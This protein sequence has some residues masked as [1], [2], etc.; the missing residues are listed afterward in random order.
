MTQSQLS[1]TILKI[2]NKKC[3]NRFVTTVKKNCKIRLIST[4]IN[5]SEIIEKWFFSNDEKLMKQQMKTIVENDVDE[6]DWYKRKLN[7][8][9]KINEI[10]E[11]KTNVANAVDTIKQSKL[12][13][14]LI[15]TMLIEWLLSIDDLFD[16]QWCQNKIQI[17]QRCCYYLLKSSWK[18]KKFWIVNERVKVGYVKTIT[19]NV[20]V[21]VSYVWRSN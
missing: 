18:W 15:L 9:W 13:E 1:K 20:K 5:W 17:E 19:I 7:D 6:N 21:N 8:N 4:M 2:K 12:I 10:N 3:D 11:N 14:E 16:N